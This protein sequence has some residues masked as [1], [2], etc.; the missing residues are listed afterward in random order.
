MIKAKLLKKKKLRENVLSLRYKLDKKVKVE[1]GQFAIFLINSERRMYSVT[2]YAP[3][4]TDIIEFIVEL[5]PNGIAST[6]FKKTQE[7]DEANIL[8]ISGVFTIKDYRKAK[9]FLCVGVGIAPIYPMLEYL[10]SKKT[11]DK[12]TL[13]WG[14]RYLKNLYLEEKTKNLKRNNSNFD[15]RICIS[16][17]T[18]IP[19]KTIF[20]RGYVQYALER[21]LTQNK[22]SEKS[23]EYYVCGSLDIVRNIRRYLTRK[24]KIKDEFVIQERFP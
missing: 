18:K 12:F 7:G 17:E 13:F 23:F 24:M 15:Y 2:N 19:D 1:P 8:G 16:R 3:K 20:E 11:D 5:V 6:F 9:V 22:E 4:E 21:Y 10:N 14:I